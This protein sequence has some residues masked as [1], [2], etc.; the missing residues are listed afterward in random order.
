MSRLTIACVTIHLACAWAWLAQPGAPPSVALRPTAKN[1]PAITML[2]KKQQQPKKRKK[3][4]PAR[5]AAA[6]APTS[7]QPPPT[8][9][10][11]TPTTPAPSAGTPSAPLDDR[12][13]EVFK[14]A[15][16]GQSDPM[17]SFSPANSKKA[18]DPNDPLA[19]IPKPAQE[20][21]ERFF[22]GG[23]SVMGTAFILSGLAVAIEAIAKVLGSPLPTFL[24]ELLVQ[25]VEP[26]LT[27]SLLILFGFSISLG[28][29][30]QL[31]LGSESTGV[32]YSESNDDDDGR[33]PSM[34]RL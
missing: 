13:D 31:Q 32:L 11:S 26:A 23:A 30:K 29:L 14:R 28:V 7:L 17:A 16:I 19:R 10:A 22:F 9:V 21:L 27:P 4:A 24:D 3:K 25:Y 12:L 5:P 2:A 18:F 1:S 15:G 33:P 20:A 6:P 8:T 34:G